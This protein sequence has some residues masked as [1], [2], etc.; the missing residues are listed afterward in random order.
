MHNLICDTALTDSRH[1]IFHTV[2]TPHLFSIARAR[3]KFHIPYL[4]L[5]EIL[6]VIGRQTQEDI[7]HAMRMHEMGC[8]R[9][10]ADRIIFMD[11][12][13]IVEDCS[14]DEFFGNLRARSER[15]QHFLSNILPH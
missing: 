7:T 3:D 2:I 9:K 10:V 6:D 5:N 12:G 13:L 8:A 11:Q 1:T 15:A 14:K 4:L